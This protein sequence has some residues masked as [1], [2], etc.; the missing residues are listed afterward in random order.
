MKIRDLS[1]LRNLSEP[2]L[3]RD[4]KLAAVTVRRID[5]DADAYRSQVW[6]VPTDG[7]AP[8]CPFTR[9]PRDT[10]PR[11]SPDG[12]WL[13]FLRAR[14]E[15]EPQLHVMP[16][17]GGEPR[18]LCEQ[19]LGA[20][21]LAWSP[22]ST[23]IAFTA[24]VPEPGRYGTDPDVP[25]AKEPPRRITTLRYR[26]DNVGFTFDRPLHLYTVSVAE[27]GAAPVRLTDGD[28]DHEDP[29]WTADGAAVAVVAA[30]HETRHRDQLSDVYLVPA[31]GGG[32]P[33]RLTATTMPVS[34]PAFTADGST[35]LFS[36]VGAALPTGRPT[37]IWSLDLSD[38]SA[39]A[40][41]LSDPAVDDADDFL[42]P[43]SRPLLVD[44]RSV[45]TM[46][47]HRGAVELASWPLDGGPA[48]TIVGGDRQVQGYDRAGDV[49]VTVIATG[50]SAGELHVFR[51]GGERALTDFGRPLAEAADIRPLE[52]VTGTSDDGYEA[53]GWLVV[54]AGDGP[55]PVLL[56]IHGGPFTQY[57]HTLFD[58][59]QVYAGAGYAVVLG[60]PRGSSGYG[61]AHGRAL[62]GA[63]GDHDT[64]DLL[65]LLDAAIED[66][67]LDGGRV[68]VMGGS[69]GGFMASWLAAHHGDRF[70]AAISE[71]AVNAWD[72]FYGSSDIGWWF[73]YT[74]P[75][76]RV[77]KSPLTHADRISVPLL[78]IHAEE[79]WRCP[80][81]QA[82]RLFVALADRGAE[83]EMLLFPGEGHELSR[84]G[85]PSHRVARF[86]AVLDWWARHLG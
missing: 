75:E 66:P 15:G 58:E 60:N 28:A 82:Q 33:R 72:S 39:R 36:G 29:C 46:R 52:E 3:T 35:L 32:Q 2:T 14:D 80:V 31:A 70:R 49:T 23:R 71:R 18:L 19:P 21:Q 7:S 10:M 78:I 44:R 83:V 38:P 84:S 76:Q 56:N 26:L 68:G 34:R 25:P 16:V 85:L 45:A 62:F 53:H 4:G 11:F 69:Y 81:E 50:T 20:A 43:S 51:D 79:D 64:A 42:A 48:T 47:L 17:T 57:G 13:A 74:G 8:P 77:A 24:R 1:L 9:G 41:R 6:T 67:R 59:A 22:D 55:F 73:D 37:A 40:R 65:A 5:L 54:P 30:R 12:R 63:L 86:D 27:D 61:E